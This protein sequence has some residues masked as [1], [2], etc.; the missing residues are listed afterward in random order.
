MEEG[1][2]TFTKFFAG[3]GA[4]IAAAVFAEQGVTVE[5]V[6]EPEETEAGK[7]WELAHYGLVIRAQKAIYQWCQDRELDPEVVYRR[8]A[9]TYNEGYAALGMGH[10]VRPVIRPMPGD[11]GGHCVLK[12]A[13]HLDHQIGEIVTHGF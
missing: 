13:R 11:I 3:E 6:E 9:E 8:F 10:V 4:E 12:N 2:R 5:V 7:L 1:I